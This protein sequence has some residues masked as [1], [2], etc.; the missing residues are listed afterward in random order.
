MG[1]EGNSAEGL[2]VRKGKEAGVFQGVDDEPR[3]QY[4]FIQDRFF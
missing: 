2:P 3:G 4:D 1:S